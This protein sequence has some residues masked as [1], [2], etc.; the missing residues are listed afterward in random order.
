MLC[1]VQ[2]FLFIIIVIVVVNVIVMIINIMVGGDAI[3]RASDFE[4]SQV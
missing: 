1:I 3:G 4:S 2:T